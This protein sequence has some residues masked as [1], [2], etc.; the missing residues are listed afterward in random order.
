MC[1]FFVKTLYCGCKILAVQSRE[2][3]KCIYIVNHTY[4]NICDNC[5]QLPEEKLDERLENMKKN[6]NKIYVSLVNG[7]SHIDYTT[8]YT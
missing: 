3:A 6:D 1:I 5:I 8:Y 2:D 4:K 7:W